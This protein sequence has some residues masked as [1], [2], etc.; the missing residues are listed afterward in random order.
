MAPAFELYWGSSP[1]LHLSSPL[2][3]SDKPEW[4]MWHECRHASGSERRSEA[5]FPLNISHSKW[6][7]GW[8]KMGQGDRN[9]YDTLLI[10]LSESLHLQSLTCLYDVTD[11]KLPSPR[12]NP[13]PQALWQPPELHDFSLGASDLCMAG[14]RWRGRKMGAQR[15]FLLWPLSLAAAPWLGDERFAWQLDFGRV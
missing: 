1:P 9:C 12:W 5:H 8:Q 13:R 10:L 6:E 3:C 7:S 4:A 2:F 11:L 14:D 15:A